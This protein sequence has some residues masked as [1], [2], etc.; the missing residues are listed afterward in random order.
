MEIG[1]VDQ[2]PEEFVWQGSGGLITKELGAAGGSR[3]SM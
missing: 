1:N 2:L 3:K